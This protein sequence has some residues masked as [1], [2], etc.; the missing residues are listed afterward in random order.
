MEVREPMDKLTQRINRAVEN[1][2]ENEALTSNLDDDAAQALLD[3]GI[4]CAQMIAQSTEWLSDIEAED[5][6]SPRL[7]AI[8]R[9]MRH[10][11]QWIPQRLEAG[12]EDNAASLAKIIEQATVI[13]GKD[14]THPGSIQQQNAFLRR[15]LA[16]SPVETIA[17]LR[18]LIEGAV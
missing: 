1:I 17:S 9:M 15:N 4:A 10:V 12:S 2:L 3:W 18:V 16:A 11:N 14:F 8:R 5:A 7:R 6:M 13:Y